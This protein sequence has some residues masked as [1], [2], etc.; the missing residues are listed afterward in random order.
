MDEAKVDLVRERLDR[1]AE[2]LG[3]A[4]SLTARHKHP[5]PR[6]AV[7]HCQQAA[8]KAL[9]ALLAWHDEPIIK[10]HDLLV[11]LKGREGH[12]PTFVVW[13]AAADVLTPYAIKFRYPGEPE[14]DRAE[15]RQAIRMAVGIYAD[16][17]TLLPAETHP[18]AQ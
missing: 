1:A 9:K 10:T 5:Y 4:R 3:A 17:L 2:D 11:L 15:V 7:Y 18:P 13:G 8:E 14:P 6:T 16:V 12:E